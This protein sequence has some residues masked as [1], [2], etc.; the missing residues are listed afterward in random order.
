[1]LLL[2]CP[3]GNKTCYK[4]QKHLHPR[5]TYS[6]ML[7]MEIL[8]R[9]ATDHPV[10]LEA[11]SALLY[12]QNRAI[13]LFEGKVQHQGPIQ[14]PFEVKHM[15]FW[16]LCSGFYAC[17]R[18]AKCHIIEYVTIQITKALFPGSKRRK[19]PRGS[20]PTVVCPQSRMSL[21]RLFG[22]CP[23]YQWKWTLHGSKDTKIVQCP[24]IC[25]HWLLN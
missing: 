17:Q 22:Y 24:T 18:E 11:L 25:Y 3:F 13:D 1:M 8:F 16:R 2:Q 4:P 20:F 6:T 21:T 23:H 7:Q 19:L 9:A 10:L 15:E 14:I 5:K 12:L